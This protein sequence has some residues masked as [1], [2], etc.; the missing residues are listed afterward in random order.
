MWGILI[1]SYVIL[2]SGY[3]WV[4]IKRQNK[5]GKKSD[6]FYMVGAPIAKRFSTKQIR[7]LISEAGMNHITKIYPKHQ[8]HKGMRDY[9]TS[10][11]GILYSLISLFT[12]LALLAASGYHP[13][14]SIEPEVPRPAYGEGDQVYPVT[15]TVEGTHIQGEVP[16]I[17][18][19]QLPDKEEAKRI[20]SLYQGQLMQVFLGDNIDSGKVSEKLT[21]PE[22]YRQTTDAKQIYL[23]YRSLTPDYLTQA[24]ELRKNLM[25]AGKYYPVALEVTLTYGE[26]SVKDVYHFNLYKEVKEG[27][28]PSTQ[29]KESIKVE[30]DKVLLAKTLVDQVSKVQWSSKERGIHGGL[31]FLLGILVAL[32]AYIYKEKELGEAVKKREERILF[33]LPNMVNKLILLI[34][35]GMTFSRAWYK[36]VADYEARHREERPLYE[37]MNRVLMDLSNGVPETE[38]LEAFGKRCRRIEVIRLSSVLS[39]NLKRGSRSMNTALM[40]LGREAWEI[41]ASEAKKLGEKASTKLLIPMAIGLLTV[42]LIVIAPIFMTMQL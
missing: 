39:Q 20:V 2:Q 17:L 11:I 7:Q 29:I 34:G 42:L 38:A 21:L 25:E 9:Q 16:L 35:A 15:F 33:D 28:P 23:T 37:E 13:S 1:G 24:G 19:E 36:I 40:T 18:E 32:L 26:A 12:L 6:L 41:R 31:V 3:I 10:R 14:H 5:E 27:T 30:A 8:W 22:K 4:A